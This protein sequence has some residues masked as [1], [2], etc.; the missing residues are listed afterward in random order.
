MILTARKWVGY[1]EHQSNE[2][3]GIY[4]ANIGKG[5]CTVFSL[6]IARCYR[7]RNF[8]GLPWCTVFVHAVAI[9]AWGKDKARKMLGCPHP[10]SRVLLRRMKRRGWLRGPEY[11]PQPG[12]IIFLHNGGGIVDHVGVVDRLEGDC[13]IS[14]EGNTV[15]PS[16]HFSEDQGGA[17]AI[18]KRQRNDPAILYYASMQVGSS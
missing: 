14:I 18:R 13:V 2:S 10:G 6:I 3:L 11:T 16:G 12:D 8:S 17:V 9:E 1:L 15:D 7:W 4:T 5:G